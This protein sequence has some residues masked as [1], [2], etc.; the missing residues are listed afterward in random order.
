MTQN[1]VHLH[2]HSHHGSILDGYGTADEMC[3]RAAELG[4]PGIGLSDHGMMAGA[5]EFNKAAKKY[6]VTGVIGL[7]AYVVPGDAPMTTHEPIFFGSGSGDNKEERSNDVSG[8]GAYTHLTMFA[9]TNEGMHNLFRLNSLAYK[10]GNY[11]KPRIDVETIAQYSAGIIGTTGC[12]SSELQTRLRLGQWNKAVEYASKMQDIFGKENYFLELMDHNMSID[13]ERSV[14][15]DL[16]KIAQKLGI[17]LLA[18]NDAHYVT[19]DDA[20]SHEHMLAINSGSTM[21]EP[22][23]ENGGKRFAFSGE[24][25]YLKSAEEMAV[26]FGNEDLYPGAMSN[27]L[28]I[29]ERANTSFEYNPNLR[30]SVP[31]P[32]GHTEDSYL[33]EISFEG[34]RTKVPHKANDPEYIERLEKEL[35]VFKQKNFSGYML[36]V[37]DFMKWSKQQGWQVGAAR[38]CLAADTNVL[39]PLGFKKINEIQVGDQVFDQLGNAVVVPQTFEYVCDEELIAITSYYGG[40]AIKMTSDHKVLVSKANRI[41]TKSQQR[42]GYKYGTDANTPE[43]LRADEV[44]VGDFVVMPKIKFPDT[45]QNFNVELSSTRQ[46][47]EKQEHSARTIADKL[48]LA[49]STVRKFLKNNGQVLGKKSQTI[50]D[51]LVTHNLTIADRTDSHTITTVLPIDS[52]IAPSYD[53]AKL[54]GIFISDGWLRTRGTELGFAQRRSEDDGTIPNLFKKLFGVDLISVD[55]KDKDLRQYYSTHKGIIKLFRE[56]FPAYVQT[57]HSKYIPLELLN[58][59]E[60]FRT[61]LLEGLWYGDGSHKGH[62]TYTT[63]SKNLA[64][65]VFTLLVSLGLQAGIKKDIRKKD[66]RPEFNK[67]DSE[68]RTSYVI[69]SIR[70]FDKKR[71]RNAMGAAFDGEYMY[72]RVR[73]IEVVPAEG[74]VYDFTVPTTNSYVTDSFVVH[75]SGG[76]SL[77][78]YV[79]DITEIDPIPHKLIFER[80]LNPERDSPPD[81]DSDF[82]DVNREKV[83]QYVRDKYGEETVAMII[84]FGKLKAKNSIKDITRIFS[85]PYSTGEALTK[86][87]PAPVSGFDI[88][89]SQILDS[90]HPRYLEGESFR[91]QMDGDSASKRIVEAALGLEGRIRATG[92]HAAGVIM[93]SKPLIDVI[94]LMTRKDDGATITQFDYPTCED[95]GLIKMDFLGIRNLT[96]VDKTIRSVEK[97]HGIRLDTKKIYESVLTTHDEK[98]YALLRAGYTLGIF[99]LDSPPIAALLKAMNVDNFGDISAVIALYRPG[100]MGMNSHNLYVERKNGRAPIIPIHAELAEPLHDILEDTFGVICYQEQVMAIAQKV[101]GYTLGGADTLRRIMGKKKKKDLDAEFPVFAAGMSGNGFSQEA[102]NALWDTLLPFAEYGFN[103]SHSAGYGLLTYLTAYLKAHYPAEFMAANLSTLTKD[104]DKTAIYLEECRRMGLKVLP[105]SISRSSLDYTPV[106]DAEIMVGLQAIR[107]VGAGVSNEIIAEAEKKEY[108]SID[109]FVNRVPGSVLNKGVLEGLSLS[110]AFDGF[111]YSR[112]ALKEGLPTITKSVINVKKKEDL[113]QFSLFDDFEDEANEPESSLKVDIPLLPEYTKKDKLALERHYL[114]LYVSDHPLSGV[115]SSL[116]KYA[117]TKI[118]SIWAGDVV[119]SSGGFGDRKKITLAGVANS[120][121]KKPTKNGDMMGRFTLEDMTGTIPALIFPKSF[122]RLGH[123]LEA[124]NIYVM[125]GSILQRDGEDPSF[126]VDSLEEIEL[127]ADGLVPFVIQLREDQI[128][129]DSMSELAEILQRHKGDMPVFLHVRKEKT[130]EVMELGKQYG[131]S[132]DSFSSG[133]IRREIMGLFG[134]DCLE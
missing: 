110:G 92:V 49:R 30:P 32:P 40:E 1:F 41:L 60:E 54:I 23:Y 90:D 64:Q 48:G 50:E 118:A 100:P 33:R 74:K 130:I 9:E 51:Y 109:D 76:G 133:R 45:L 46:V 120:V 10:Y 6:G 128:N 114:G 11:R 106:S 73:Q 77:L 13:L 22:T 124:D 25:Y 125:T 112:R 69:T 72:Q 108:V 89:L 87:I 83:M 56:L 62:T 59:S 94:P 36:V 126:A 88:S 81:I 86:L 113:G 122:V 116:D 79:T 99:Q 132:A 65:G 52:Q 34:L 24:E 131:I 31:L 29:A 39:T 35:A 105:P 103:K 98:T 44:E 55:H 2:N 95:L 17:P 107:G 43:W 5:Y 3:K 19:K 121:V 20:L 15:G 47:N 119:G 91:E 97:N 53:M 68:G 58:S 66:M 42:L 4:M 104:Q 96:V 18:T 26:Y 78:A 129:G 85:E 7:E 101:A 123:K 57:A 61:G 84:T 134:V 28:L 127:T 82:D 63:V 16:M 102:I 21:D 70:E 38:G 80:F 117:D 75:N 27:T 14:R 115:A 93:S 37:S 111:G 12:P 71:I 8:R 67:Y